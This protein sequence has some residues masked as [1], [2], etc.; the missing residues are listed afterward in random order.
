MS[1]GD[2][3]FP[4]ALVTKMAVLVRLSVDSNIGMPP[5]P[6]RAIVLLVPGTN[7]VRFGPS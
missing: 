1:R 4:S 6:L 7:F 2:K 5:D 3:N